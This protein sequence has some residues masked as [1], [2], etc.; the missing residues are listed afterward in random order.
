MFKILLK[1]QMT[2]IFRGYYYDSKKNKKRSTTST[3]MFIFLY[4]FIMI[5]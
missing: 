5:G 1:K 2:E 3:I 4:A